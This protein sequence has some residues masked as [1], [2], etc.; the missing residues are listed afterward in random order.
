MGLFILNYFKV[1]ASHQNEF[2]N[3]TYQLLQHS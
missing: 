1:F 3:E 2:F